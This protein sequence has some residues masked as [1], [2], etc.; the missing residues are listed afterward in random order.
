MDKNFRPIKRFHKKRARSLTLDYECI[1]RDD[2]NDIRVCNRLLSISVRRTP[3]EL[4]IKDVAIFHLKIIPDL[5]VD[6]DDPDFV[7]FIFM[8]FCYA[9]HDDQDDFENVDSIYHLEGDIILKHATERLRSNMD[10]ILRIIELSMRLNPRENLK[11]M[12]CMILDDEKIIYLCK[13]YGYPMM[14]ELSD[15]LNKNKYIFLQLVPY[16]SLKIINYNFTNDPELMKS[17]VNILVE[18]QLLYEPNTSIINRLD[19]YKSLVRTSEN[20]F[21]VFYESLKHKLHKGKWI[22]LCREALMHYESVYEKFS[23]KEKNNCIIKRIQLFKRDLKKQL[24]KN[25]MYDVLIMF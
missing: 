21:D 4:C 23:E 13:R 3:S 16:R 22:L 7:C 14:R 25:D 8:I 2:Y 19:Y 9:R 15:H 10:F 5:K 17:I 1:C 24:Y 11:L 18:K 20:F 12:K 6:W